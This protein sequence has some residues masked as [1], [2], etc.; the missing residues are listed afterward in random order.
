MHHIAVDFWSID[1][2]LDEL[3][4]LYAAQ[5]GGPT[6]PACPNAMSTMS[7]GRTGRRGRMRGT[8]LGILAQQLAGDLPVMQLP[9]DR[10][11]RVAQTYRG[12]VHR[13]T[14][15]A[16]LTADLKKTGRGAG[17]TP[18]MTLLAAYATLLHRYNG[19]DDLLIGSPFA[20]REYAGLRNSSATLPIR[21]FFVPICTVTRRSSALL[22]R[23]KQT[24]FGALRHQDYPFASAGRAV[25]TGS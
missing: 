16:E 22:G 23:I 15:D 14:L 1:V 8:S 21:W 3:R 5:F 25:P 2:M 12:A 20:N 4:L 13:F 11:R 17:S 9:T 18:Y 6:P 19:Q 24:V 7:T 10:P